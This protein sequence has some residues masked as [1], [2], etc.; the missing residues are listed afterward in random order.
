[1]LP[2]G[3]VRYKFVFRLS[4]STSVPPQSHPVHSRDSLAQAMGRHAAGSLYLAWRLSA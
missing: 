1:M 3:L 2:A 4:L